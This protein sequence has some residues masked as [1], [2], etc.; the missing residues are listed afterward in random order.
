MKVIK[1]SG[2]M[3]LSIASGLLGG[4]LFETI[5]KIP[6]YAWGQVDRVCSGLWQI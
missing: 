6:K 4:Y 3:D 5:L 2:G 1:P